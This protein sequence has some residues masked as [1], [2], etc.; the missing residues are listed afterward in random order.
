MDG[1]KPPNNCV[2]LDASVTYCSSEGEVHKANNTLLGDTYRVWQTAEL[3]DLAVIEYQFSEPRYIKAIDITNAGC[4][5]IE[6]LVGY[7]TW[8]TN[9]YQVMVQL[10]TFMAASDSKDNT[11]RSRSMRFEG[12]KITSMTA[13]RRWEKVRVICKQP[14]I[15][16][17]I[18]IASIKFYGKP[19]T[20]VEKEDVL[21]T[22]PVPLAGENFPVPQGKLS[23][24]SSNVLNSP[25]QLDSSATD[26][27]TSMTDIETTPTKLNSSKTILDSS[28]K[29]LNR[30][31]SL[32]FS[33]SK[34]KSI[35][36]N[37]LPGK[38]IV[39]KKPSELEEEFNKVATN[40]DDNHHHHKMDID[41]PSSSSSKKPKETSK[42]KLVEPKDEDTE[43]EDG[44]TDEDDNVHTIVVEP[45]ESKYITPFGLILKGVVIVI[46][47]IVNPRKGE[48]RVKALEMGADYKPD[49]C[50][51]AT[52]LISPYIGTP[53]ADACDGS[54][55]APE[56]IDECYKQKT[57]LA[58]KSFAVTKTFP[59]QDSKNK[60]QQSTSK[61]VGKSISTSSGKKKKGG[62]KKKSKSTD[63]NDPTDSEDEDDGL[64]NEYDLNDDFI[65]TGDV[66]DS[67]DDDD[68]DA[69]GDDE[70]SD[71]DDPWSERRLNKKR[72][73]EDID[74]LLKDGLGFLKREYGSN[75]AMI[76]QLSSS[77][78][79]PK[80]K[81]HNRTESNGKNHK[82]QADI[83]Y[84][85][86]DEETVFDNNL[87]FDF[88]T[89]EISH[90]QIKAELNKIVSLAPTSDKSP[91]PKTED[92]DT[93]EDEDIKPEFFAP[94]NG[95]NKS[96]SKSA[97]TTETS[98]TKTTPST[99]NNDLKAKSTTTTTTTN[100][101]TTTISTS[102]PKAKEKKVDAVIVKGK[103]YIIDPL[104]TFFD[105]IN[106]YLSLK[107]ENIK[108]QVKR[109]IIAYKG[110]LNIQ[111]TESTKFII[112]DKNWDRLFDII[113][114]KYPSVTFL[115]PSF[116]MKSHNYQKIVL[117]ESH[118]IS[119]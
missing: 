103:E 112:T 70:N 12:S 23:I 22:T 54:I 72:E 114:A 63:P 82:K 6:V 47:G 83:E 53:K 2:E 29:K 28:N 48:L 106:F 43:E 19:E 27:D 68:N 116:I 20:K 84:M 36:T 74:D 91:P 77:T 18:G 14:F 21:A 97:L 66:D 109:Y 73:K 86:K 10:T 37:I 8:E 52:H 65:D 102:P 32:T 88:G 111:P 69:D 61:S 9:E 38:C 15:K 11:N 25:G 41:T 104:P 118:E 16:T 95:A 3:T 31:G 94:S 107:D 93:D 64:P 30:S 57:R 67:A 105:G 99:N 5:F 89:Q 35:L 42:P 44:H 59:K 90:E 17:N 24:S 45:K 46:G 40:K 87:L 75:D 4:S 78:K 98:T 80:H 50:K 51:G 92:F 62:K 115:K 79:K 34:S 1:S 71:D 113:K 7:S 33:N 58:I 39:V 49:W 119:K 117:T 76:K 100:N 81:H 26:L 85:P 13:N 101:N 55:V 108:N 96:K 56:W 110:T 60:Q